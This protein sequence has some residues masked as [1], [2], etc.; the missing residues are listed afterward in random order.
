MQCRWQWNDN[1]T[2]RDVAQVQCAHLAELHGYG[3]GDTFG[4]HGHAILRALTT[5]DGHDTLSD[6]DVLDAQGETFADP[7]A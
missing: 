2:R 6:V 4:Q 1:A 3:R 5:P 7:E